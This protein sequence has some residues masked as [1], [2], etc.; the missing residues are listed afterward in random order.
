MDAEVKADQPVVVTEKGSVGHILL[1]RPKVLNSLNLDMV[2]V[3]DAALDRFEA[4][5]GIAAVVISGAGERGLCAGGDIRVLHES[6]KAGTD[7]AE[8][9]WREEYRLNAR[10]SR[11]PKPYV[12]FMH[13]ITMGGGVGISA[14]GSHRIV[15]ERTRFAMPETGIGFFPDVGASWL[16]TR[17]S[18]EFGTFLALTGEQIGAGEAIA[19]GLADFCVA[20]DRLPDLLAALA[21]LPVESSAETVSTTIA[22]FSAAPPADRFA[23]VRDAIDRLFAFD[24]VEAIL[25]ALAD[26]G[27]DFAQKTSET[28]QAKSPTSLKATLALLRLG[29]ASDTIEQCLEHEFAACA[30]VLKS[31]DFY[32]GIRAAIIDKDRNPHWLPAA[33]PDIGQDIIARYLTPYPRPLFAR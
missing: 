3:I 28:M 8:T 18:G 5:K 31:D 26:E 4:D 24:S 33:L 2:R 13:G 12:A 7:L 20:S 23:D 29:R 25:A 17:A 11:F 10:I 27:S 30:A 22:G 14:H 9:F 32:E 6:G 16:L 1:N 21:A 15:T 19:A